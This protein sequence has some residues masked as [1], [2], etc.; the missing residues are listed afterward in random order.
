[1][2][3]KVTVVLAVLLGLTA[4]ALLGLLTELQQEQQF[5]VFVCEPGPSPA[6]VAELAEEARRITRDAAGD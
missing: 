3:F 1:M 4:G 6:D 5:T 2:T